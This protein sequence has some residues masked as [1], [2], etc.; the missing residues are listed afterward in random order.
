MEIP[1]SITYLIG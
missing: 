1:D